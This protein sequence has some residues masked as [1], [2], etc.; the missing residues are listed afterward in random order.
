MLVG[1]V[2]HTMQGFINS[3]FNEINKAY[4]WSKHAL[5]VRYTIIDKDGNKLRSID[6]KTDR[7]L[8]SK[9]YQGCLED[10]DAKYYV[11][12]YIEGTTAESILYFRM[13]KDEIKEYDVT[14]LSNTPFTIEDI[15]FSDNTEVNITKNTYLDWV[16]TSIVP[17]YVKFIIEK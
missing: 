11:S 12:L 9:I 16:L 5:N 8:G 1:N 6:D 13:T 17:K 3:I 4:I 2:D 14:K 7:P 15:T 10:I